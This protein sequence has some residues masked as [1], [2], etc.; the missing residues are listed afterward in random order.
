MTPRMT[1]AVARPLAAVTAGL[2]AVVT[3]AAASATPSAAGSTPSP[4]DAFSARASAQIATA[5]KVKANLTPAERKIDSRLVMALHRSADPALAKALPSL[6]DRSVDTAGG[7]V[8]VDITARVSAALLTRL[9]GVGA[10]ITYAS[11]TVGSVRATVPMSSLTTVAGWSQV[12]S[13]RTADSFLTANARPAPPPA[14]KQA[15]ES[16]VRQNLARA[17]ATPHAGSVDSEGDTT[18]A[19]ATART[20]THVTGIGVK[21]CVLSDGVDSLAAAQASG[22]LPA[23][24]DV[25]PGQ[26]GSGDEGTAMLEIVHD[27]AP[28]AGLGFATA[29]ISGASFADNI[30]ALRFQAHC[31]IIVDDVLYYAETT[32]QDGPIAQA[33]IDVTKNGAMYFSSAGNEGSVLSG[34]SAN[35]EHTFVGSGQSIGKFAGVAHDFDPGPGVQVYEPVS[36]SSFL[37]AAPAILQWA[38][39]NG[40]AAD[41]YDLYLLDDTGALVAFSQDVQDGSQDPFEI[42]GV[43][44]DGLRLAVVKYSGADR[45]FQLSTMRGRYRDADGLRAYV[46]PGITR[47]HS[48]VK[49]AFSV[50]AAPA[51]DS[52]GQVQPDDPVGPT[53]PYP[54]VFTARQ[55]LEVFS[56]DGPRRMFFAPDGTPRAEV[57]AKPDITAADGVSTSLA[58]FDPFYGT[59]A[60][61]PHAA[62]IA[63]LVRSGNPRATSADVR[64]AFN[65][66]ALDPAPKGVDARAGHGIIRADRVLRYTGATPQPLV[67]AGLATVVSTSDGDQFVEPGET[68]TVGIPVTNVGDGP[69]ASVAARFTP[70]PGVAVTPASRRLGLVR[71]GQSRHLTETVS[72]PSSWPVGTPIVVTATVTFV[73]NGSPTRTTLDIPTGQPTASQAFSYTGPPVAIPDDDVTGASV[74]IPVRGV[75]PASSVTFS[76]DGDTCT[77]DIAATTVGIDHTWVGDLMGTLTSPSGAT[78]TLFSHSGSEGNNMC[79]VVFDDSATTPFSSVTSDSAPFTGTWAPTTPLAALAG[80]ADADGSWTFTAVDGALADTGSIRAVTLHL[81]GYVR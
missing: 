72:V 60:A 48:A 46:T 17:L 29:F 81:A 68:A 55:R 23:T 42:L 45:Y 6:A 4:P 21:V 2:V 13:V 22:D 56:S 10:S 9:H 63:A 57:R 15:R 40:A 25:L 71:A 43:N 16:L 3:A 77:T 24:V 62:A 41:D 5:Q 31:N 74:Q 66:T 7:R 12:R 58:D 44:G 65:A 80:G 18:H 49:A 19:A 26:E 69:A 64:A 52:I 35:Y 28:G 78:A 37:S 54:G 53:G 79:Q 1:R 32:F 14:T 47:G 75:G 73:G 67:Q 59:S 76:V 8:S 34:T 70:P 11:T 51:K 39:P 20:R 38:D 36:F 30:R 27:L 61:A 50:A 33:V